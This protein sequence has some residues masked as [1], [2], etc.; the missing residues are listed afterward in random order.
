MEN[1]AYVGISAEEVK[2][3]E[4]KMKLLTDMVAIG[5]NPRTEIIVKNG[6]E[7]IVYIAPKDKTGKIN[8]VT[9][10]KDSGGNYNATIYAVDR[11]SANVLFEGNRYRIHYDFSENFF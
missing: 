2:G 7:D 10:R 4:K 1:L 11:N 3:L 6:F 5:L 9:L 8:S